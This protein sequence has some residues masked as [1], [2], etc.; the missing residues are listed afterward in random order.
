MRVDV[1]PRTE[2]VPA[3]GRT[4][5]AGWAEDAEALE[6]LR[7]EWNPLLLRS[8]ANRVFLTWEWVS[9]W[10]RH[11]GTGRDL[12]VLL[13]RDGGGV[14]RG[15]APLYLDVKSTPLGKVRKIQFLGYGGDANP[16]FLNFVFEAGWE[17]ACME[18]AWDALV[19]RRA[20]W[21]LLKLT[22]LCEEAPE[23]TLLPEGAE[24]RGLRVHR[25][26]DTVCPYLPLPDDFEALLA[27]FRPSLRK[28]IRY[29]LRKFQK[30]P[31]AEEVSFAAP[32]RTD[33]GIEVLA[34]LHQ[35]RMEESK[36]GGNFKRSTYFR[37]H[38]DLMEEFAKHGWL[39]LRILRVNGKDAAANYA[40]LYD[41]VLYGYQMGLNPEFYKMSL[42]TVLLTR[43]VQ[44]LIAA[45]YREVDMLRGRSHW[46]YRWTQRERRNWT[47]VIESSGL[48]GRR[49]F[50]SDLSTNRPGVILKRVLPER[51]F[52]GLQHSVRAMKARLTGKKGP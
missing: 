29:R 21:D 23:A 10:W 6:R 3:G 17:D 44:D 1:E 19:A 52:A 26:L 49:A 4:L 8:K 46:K 47:F 7:E 11:F 31:G 13:L 38:R 2:P 34:H 32:G 51:V 35:L 12:R 50:W 43:I 22:D 9:I 42:G 28:E 20:E 14:L 39:E 41:G 33:E 15:I 37:F 5:T 30:E 27:G 25:F 24:K 16:D 45:G 40:F 36:R 48:R 18:A